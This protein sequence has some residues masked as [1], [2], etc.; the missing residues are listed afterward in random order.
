M[1]SLLISFPLYKTVPFLFEHLDTSLGGRKGRLLF[2]EHYDMSIV[3]RTY[4]G[5]K[6]PIATCWSFKGRSKCRAT[7]GKNR[8]LVTD[9]PIEF[10]K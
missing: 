9:E 8:Q 6:H 3:N 4:G 7:I 10:E 5:I 1:T 2:Y